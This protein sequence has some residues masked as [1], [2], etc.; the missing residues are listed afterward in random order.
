MAD[1]FRPGDRTPSSGIY[2]VVHSVQHAPAHQVIAL[3]GDI[4]PRCQE[5]TDEVR[6]KL[7]LSAVYISAHPFFLC[8]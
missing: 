1:I 4:F 2:R 6:F 7:A 8:A 5:C 3:Y